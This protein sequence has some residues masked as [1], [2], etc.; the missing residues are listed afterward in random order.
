L[1]GL[2]DAALDD[3]ALLVEVLVE[4]RAPGAGGIARDDRL[5]ALRRGGVA[6]VVGVVGGVGDDGFGGRPPLAPS[7]RC[8]P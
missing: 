2:A 1:L 8:R 5:G 6:D 3:M 7:G 4:G